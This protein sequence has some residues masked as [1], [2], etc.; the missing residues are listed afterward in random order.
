MKLYTWAENE[1]KLFGVCIA[2]DSAGRYVMEAKGSGKVV[3][4]DPSSLEEVI[5]LTADVTFQSGK[6]H[7][8]YIVKEGE[9]TPGDVLV[10]RRSKN[11]TA[12]VNVVCV[13]KREGNWK[14]L[15]ILT[16]IWDNSVDTSSDKD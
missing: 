8:T 6:Q 1:E 15:E 9:V 13:G 3:A 5:P 7:Y 11:E 2:V 10:I 12:I 14:K 4:I 16:K